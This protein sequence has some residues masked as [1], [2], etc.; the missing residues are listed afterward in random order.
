MIFACFFFPSLE[1]DEFELETVKNERKL[2]PE[3]KKTLDGFPR[4]KRFFTL[5]KKKKKEA[6]VKTPYYSGDMASIIL[7]QRRIKYWCSHVRK[8]YFP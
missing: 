2:R 1:K 7:V 6:F 3:R 8:L 4:L 5:C